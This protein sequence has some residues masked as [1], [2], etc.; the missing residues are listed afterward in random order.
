MKRTLQEMMGDLR[1]VLQEGKP[2]LVRPGGDGRAGNKLFLKMGARLHDLLDAAVS[3]ASMIDVQARR[4]AK[5]DTFGA[6]PTEWEDV[7]ARAVD[8]SNEIHAL[9]RKAQSG[10]GIGTSYGR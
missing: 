6:D 2:D 1:V 8:L 3:Q 10:K 5:G 7:A 4:M 9:D